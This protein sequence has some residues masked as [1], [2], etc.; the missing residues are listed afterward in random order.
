MIVLEKTAINH[1]NSKD[2]AV[3]SRRFVN[4]YKS[5]GPTL[6]IGY[7]ARLSF[8]KKA[9][10][11]ERFVALACIFMQKDS[12]KLIHF[13]DKNVEF[14]ESKLS[15]AHVNFSVTQTNEPFGIFVLSSH[16]HLD[17]ISADDDQSCC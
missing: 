1:A 9:R 6:L 16:S 10:E 13:G 12:M 14:Y 17:L 3:G 15:K 8:A 4:T 11:R 2:F 5:V 7:F